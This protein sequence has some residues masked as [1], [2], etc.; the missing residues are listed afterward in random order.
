MKRNDLA[1][2]IGGQAGDGSLATGEL[3]SKFFRRNGFFVATDK[4]FPSRIR[5]GHT[6]YA[7]RGAQKEIF[8]I[9][10]NIDVLLAFDEDSI[11]L[12]L[13]EIESGGLLIYDNSRKDMDIERKDIRMYKMP[14]ANIAKDKIGLELIKNTMALG[15]LAYLFNFNESLMRE[16]IHDSYKN[17]SEKIIE[18]NIKAFEVGLE[19]AKNFQKME[20]YKI[21]NLG[22]REDTL[23]LMGN[24]AIGLGA[25]AAGCKFIAAYPITPASD[26]LEF[27]SKHLPERGGIAIQAESEIAAIN[28]AIGAGYAGMRSMAVTSGPG[29]DLKTEA[30]GLASMIEQPVV[31]LDAMRSGPSTGMATKTEQSDLFHAIYGGHGEKPRIV[32]APG[33]VEEA[34]YFSFHAFNLAEKYQVPVIILSDELISWNKQV[35]KKFKLDGLK[36]ERGK[37]MLKIESQDREFK[38]Y[39]FT[40]DGISPRPI[41]GV[42]NGIHLETGDEHDEYGHITEKIPNRN[43]MMEKRM[44]RMDFMKKDLFPSI[45]QGEGN[46]AIVGLG[47]TQGPI[48][49]AIEQLN[50]RNVN[51]KYIRIRTLSPFL[52]DVKDHL[53]NV[54]LAFFV[55]QN[56]TGQLENLVRLYTGFDKTYAIRKY[57]G[58]S[59]KPK[60]ISS[61]ILEVLGK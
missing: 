61:K 28:M 11:S 14:L 23:L 24:E 41:P 42:K 40:E 1:V 16:T 46:I 4:D 8:S 6:S 57:D 12:H 20:N 22:V 2:R 45:V 18:E 33:N 7:I 26:V 5:G 27:L 47:S 54:D 56:Y 51:V 9:G 50:E 53:K 37:I 34:F 49:E 31:V 60:M 15:V 48:M 30:L 29:F 32:I 13:D 10:D 59:F 52:D 38:R 25:M 55:E 39:E 19:H 44:K 36:I 43:K 35:V 3:L 21:E 17:K 58:R